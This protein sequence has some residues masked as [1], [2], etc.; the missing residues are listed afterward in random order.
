MP[1]VVLVRWWGLMLQVILHGNKNRLPIGKHD[2]MA[3]LSCVL[4][5]T[6]HSGVAVTHRLG[7]VRSPAGNSCTFSVDISGSLGTLREI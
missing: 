1:W 2:S 5:E 3:W 6:S 7:P 4:L